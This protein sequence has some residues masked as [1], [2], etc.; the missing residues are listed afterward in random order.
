MLM[1]MEAMGPNSSNINP[2]A[3]SGLYVDVENLLSDGQA[4]I[5]KLIDD[6]PSVAPEP[7]RLSIYVRADLVELW[8]LWATSQFQEL[9][10]DVKG[11][12]HFSAYSSKNSADIAIATNA[13]S[14]L[15]LGRIG[16][17]VV[18][19][20][21][22]D[23]ISLYV[24]IRDE[25]YRSQWQT[26][27]VPFLW[28]VTDRDNSVSRTVRQYFPPEQLHVLSSED[29]GLSPANEV[30]ALLPNAERG[31]S[32]G[33][34]PNWEEIAQAIIEQM[35][36]GKFKSTDC[37]GIIRKFWPQHPMSAAAGPAFGIEFQKNVWPILQ[38]MGV[39][40]ANPGKKPIRYEI[41]NSTRRL[42]L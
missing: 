36:I 6:W 32:L 29:I 25:M 22:S 10:V 18:L 15:L 3:G 7:S 12:Q 14:D 17:V 11:I 9:V 41:L 13:M 24:S 26:T 1:N 19:S 5:R 4:L 34:A 27:R 39:Q 33:D 23:F 42:K 16:H 8:R 28:V 35:P 21:D 2:A 20:D 37:Q 30:E 40:I 38:K 31:P